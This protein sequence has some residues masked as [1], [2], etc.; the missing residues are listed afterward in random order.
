MRLRLWP[1]MVFGLIG[2]NVAV[3]ATTAWLAGHDPSFAVEPDYDARAVRWDDASRQRSADQSLGWQ[4]VLDA[5][6]ILTDHDAVIR[7]EARVADAS[8]D[9]L[10]PSQIQVVAFPSIRAAA[11]Q[12]IVMKPGA[13]GLLHGSLDF[14]HPG[15][16]RFD[17]SIIAG[18]D[19]FTTRLDR[20]MAD[21]LGAGRPRSDP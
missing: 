13:D 20:V 15:A 5:E 8:G 12:S 9:A 18:A 7:L 4:V 2:L 17:L 19:T 14:T 1:G 6:P 21:P 3:V 16:W 11:R 10:H